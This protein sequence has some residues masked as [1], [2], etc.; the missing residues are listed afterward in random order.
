[1]DIK[2]MPMDHYR[3]LDAI[4]KCRTI[5]L[6]GHIDSCDDCGH[7]RISYNSCRNRHCPKCQ[8]LNKEMWIIMQEDMLLPVVYYHVVFTLPQELNIICRFNPHQMYDLL[9]NSAWHVLNSFAS[10]PKWIEA[11]TSAT[12][13]LHTWSQTLALHPHVH[14]IVPNGGLDQDGHWKFPSKGHNNFVF[15]VAAMKKVFRG[16][17]MQHLLK[18]VRLESI[19]IPKH[20]FQKYG[21]I[22]NW[23]KML[24]SKDWVI[25]TKKPFSGPHKVIKYVGRYSNKIAITN[26]RIILLNKQEN[27]VTFSYKDY[28]DK[29]REKIMTLTTHEFVRLFNKLCHAI[30]INLCV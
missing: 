30:F 22:E 18:M 14:C 3:I 17:F 27:L 15:P 16:Y 26:A 5:A 29:G 9:F 1:M 11:K 2:S 19:F 13:L 25:F 7:L 20:Y 21:S 28:K 24:I 10:D 8:G 12:M 6:G 23:R 4:S